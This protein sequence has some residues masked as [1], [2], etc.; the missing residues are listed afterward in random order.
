M[1][2]T[3]VAPAAEGGLVATRDAALAATLRTARDYGN[4]GDYDCLFPGLNARMSELHA[5]V[6]LSSLARLP[7]R[8]AHRGALAAGFAEVAGGLPGLRFPVVDEGDTSTF[9]DLTLILDEEAFGLGAGALGRALRAEGVDT[10]RYF[11]PPVHRQRAYAALGQAESLP[12]TDALSGAV[13]TV[14]LWS[15]MD[16]ETVRRTARAVVRI[17]AHAERVRAALA[18]VG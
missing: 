3:K 8:V 9:K 7:E 14:P 2:P 5:A 4:P 12:L 17:Q 15:H 10:R 1:S 13:L 6:G 16:A 11:H 18:A